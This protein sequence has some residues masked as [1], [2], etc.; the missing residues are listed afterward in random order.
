M[1]HVMRAA[2]GRR[3]TLFDGSGQEWTAEVRRLGRAEVELQVLAGR[4]VDREL[5]VEVTLA[6]ALPK[7]ERQK[8]LVEKLV[9][10]GIAR[11]VPLQMA[12]RSEPGPP[13]LE[14]LRRGVIEASKQCGRNR[15]MEVTAPK[16]WPICWPRRPGCRIAG[17]PIRTAGGEARTL[18]SPRKKSPRRADR[19][20]RGPGRWFHRRRIGR[21]RHG[22]VAAGRLGKK[23]PSRRDGGD[24]PGGLGRRANDIEARSAS[25][26]GAC[27]SVARALGRRLGPTDHSFVRYVCWEDRSVVFLITTIALLN[28]VLGFTMAWYL[29][30]GPTDLGTAWEV[31][32]ASRALILAC[33]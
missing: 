2:P 31:L 6:S 17:S 26:G 23:D 18:R 14:R 27:A 3:V 8:W 13:A 9:E 16:A 12:G 25:E 33:P 11:L 21:R 20:G 32:S 10:L 4:L 5:P 29:G 15:L 28:I 7:G 24:L 19:A 1:I 30:F 22:R